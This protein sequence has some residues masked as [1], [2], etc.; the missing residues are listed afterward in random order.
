MGATDGEYTRK[1]LDELRARCI[2]LTTKEQFVGVPEAHEREFPADDPIWWCA[3]TSEALGPDG[4]EVC[5]AA[6]HAP[7]RAC[8]EGPVRL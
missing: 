5:R 4:S 8:Y 7:G 1:V 3:R 6:C 2:H